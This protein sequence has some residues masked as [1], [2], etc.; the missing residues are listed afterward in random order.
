MINVSNEYKDYIRNNREFV[1]DVTLTLADSTVLSFGNEDIMSGGIEIEDATSDSEFG[2]GSAI[3][4]S[5]TLTLDNSDGRLSNYDFTDAEFSVKIGLRLSNSV[6]YLDKGV[7]TVD[8]PLAIG[9]IVKLVA[10][11]NMYKFDRAFKD[12]VIS[13]PISAGL[14]LQ[15]VCDY[16]GV[17]LATP[18]FLNSDFIVKERPYDEAITC[19][20]IVSWIA[21]LSGNFAR[22][23]KN[24][25]LELRWYDHTVDEDNID[26]YH[27]IVDIRD[28]EVATDDVVITGVSILYTLVE[29]DVDGNTTSNEYSIMYGSEGYVLELPNNK[30]ITSTDDANYIINSIGQNIVGMRF[31][32]LSVSVVSDPSIEAGDVAYVRDIRDNAYF[33]VITELKFIIGSYEKIS[34][35][36]ESPNKKSTTRYSSQSKVIVEAKKLVEDER[37]ARQQALQSL[38]DELEAIEGLHQTIETVNGAKIYYLHNA[39][40]VAESTIIWKMTKE[41]FG[42]STDGGQTWNAGLE[43]DGDAIVQRL[44]AVGIDAQYVKIGDSNVGAIVGG[45]RYGNT[46]YIDGGS[47]YT[48]SIKANQIDVANLFA[49]DITATGTIDGATLKSTSGEIAGWTIA[50]YGLY[51]DAMMAGFLTHPD[52]TIVLYVGNTT[53][54]GMISDIE[55]GGDANLPNFWVTKDGDIEGRSL[56]VSGDVTLGG[57]LV[58]SG[59]VTIPDNRDA[60]LQDMP[61]QIPLQIGTMDGNNLC[62]D[63][64]EVMARN[65]MSPS[66]LHINADGGNVTINNA[67]DNGGTVLHTGNHI[68]DSGTIIVSPIAGGDTP[69]FVEFNKLFTS[70]PSVMIVADTAVPTKVLSVSVNDIQTYG[71]MAYVYRTNSTNTRINWLA[72]QHL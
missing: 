10:L 2:V 69:V 59:G 9:N 11:D 38:A 26:R 32:P 62:L 27:N 12:V 48:N 42:V 1:T 31:R 44:N 63:N 53:Y 3:I 45:W 61:W 40:T 8:T 51:N 37:T 28:F 13:F 22:C 14:L 55:D 57:E 70:K 25:E 46:T 33:T 65:G 20:E 23:D 34:C 66:T 30:L 7:F 4:N 58:A 17:T 54:S 71:F 47:I 49:Q 67:T 21:Q 36:A 72:V 29:T 64:N 19:R 41:A 68:V 43:A 6:E 24:G 60:G 18:T 5:C 16:C 52:S 50:D 15:T 56:G 35:E 39:P